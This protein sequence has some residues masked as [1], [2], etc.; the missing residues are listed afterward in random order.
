MFH[1]PTDRLVS[2]DHTSARR[3]NGCV[4]RVARDGENAD[5][6]VL[7]GAELYGVSEAFDFAQQQ[8]RVNEAR[9]V[10][11]WGVGQHPSFFGDGEE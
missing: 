10:A 11:R 1:Y 8:R 3:K 4:L 9:A 6:A 7:D 2:V 5:V